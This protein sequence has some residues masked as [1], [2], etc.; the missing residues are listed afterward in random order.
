[1]GTVFAVKPEGRFHVVHSFGLRNGSEPRGTL[2]VHDGNLNGAT[3][4]GGAT[5]KG[6]VF[7]VTP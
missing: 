6:V 2:P 4:A 5:Y 1:V 3:A 7:D